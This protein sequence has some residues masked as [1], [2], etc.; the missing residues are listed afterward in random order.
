MRRAR[1]RHNTLAG[2]CAAAIMRRIPSRWPTCARKP[3]SRA[4]ASTSTRPREDFGLE[5]SISSVTG[6]PAAAQAAAISSRCH[7]LGM[8][9]EVGKLLAG[10]REAG[11]NA[12]VCGVV[13]EHVRPIG[14]RGDARG[15]TGDRG[16][17]NGI[18]IELGLPAGPVNRGQPQRAD[19]ERDLAPQPAQHIV[20]RRLG[21]AIRRGRTHRVVLADRRRLVEVADRRNRG[22]IDER[23]NA[24]VHRGVEQV[25]AA[26]HVDGDDAGR[27][28]RHHHGAGD[29][30]SMDN[31]RY[32]LALQ[33]R[34]QP[35]AIRQIVDHLGGR[36]RD[37]IKPDRPLSGSRE[38]LHHHAPD[39]TTRTGDKRD[40]RTHEPSI[41]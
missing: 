7:A 28:V 23:A 12:G 21:A 24:A 14:Q 11:S 18:D 34:A 9:H 27:V 22:A 6:H 30:A 29:A 41:G 37:G 35:V 26:G 5:A 1:V 15:F 31:V 17:H 16:T 3:K 4:A 33:K 13:D 25:H 2:Y 32:A 36:G 20:H 8:G 19:V 40:D 10:V 38:A 39:E